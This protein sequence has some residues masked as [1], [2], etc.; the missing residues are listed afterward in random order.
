MQHE[1]TV[2]PQDAA[3]EIRKELTLM[4]RKLRGWVRQGTITEDDAA[5]QIAR[6]QAALHIIED[7]LDDG[8]MPGHILEPRIETVE[9]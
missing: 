1:H 3:T 4:G 9:F 2:T 6:F 5:R 8:N 7:C